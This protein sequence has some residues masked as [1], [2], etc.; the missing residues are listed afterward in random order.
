MI[1]NNNYVDI[2]E[3]LF[4]YLLIV[5]WRFYGLSYLVNKKKLVE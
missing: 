4:E 5:Y 1:I 3:Y 2:L